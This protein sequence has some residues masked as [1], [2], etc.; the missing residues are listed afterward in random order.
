MIAD[1]IN[2]AFEF[3]MAFMLA[4]S[5]RRLLKDKRVHGWSIWSVAW[6]TAW[7]FWNLYYYPHLGQYWSLLGGLAV[8]TVNSTW[9]ALHLYYERN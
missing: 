5:V 6:P 7:G 2:G 9:I 1:K 4:L 3:G 8:V